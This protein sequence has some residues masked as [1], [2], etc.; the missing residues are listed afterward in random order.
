MANTTYRQICER[1]LV[2]MG[3]NRFASDS[4][5]NNGN[6]DSEK[7]ALKE[8]ISIANQRIGRLHRPRFL[9]REFTFNTADGDNSYDIDSST[10]VERLSPDS[11]YI[12]TAGKSR[13]LTYYQGGYKQWKRDY[14]EG[15]PT[16]GVPRFWF[17]LPATASSPNAIGFSPPP[18][19]TYA[20]NYSAYLKPLMLTT[21]SQ[22]II[23]PP[24]HEEALVIAGAAYLAILQ[25]EGKSIDFDKILEPLLSELSQQTIGPLD[26][27]HTYNLG[28]EIYPY[29]Q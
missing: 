24:D 23:W 3:R 9:L 15:E 6:I 11:F 27:V 10:N 2:L 21:A 1:V 29:D 4:E 13:E 8:F 16:E 12:S 5:F 22:E 7:A 18:D 26:E 20:V 17:A 14:P 28:L 19:G 25:S